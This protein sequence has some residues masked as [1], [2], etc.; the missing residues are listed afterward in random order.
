MHLIGF[1]AIKVPEALLKVLFVLRHSFLKS[2]L[3]HQAFLTLFGGLVIRGRNM[4]SDKPCFRMINLELEGRR[5]GGREVL[6]E[7][8]LVSFFIFVAS[9]GL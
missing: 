4:W 2:S 7:Q 6:Q 3:A 9:S 5:E 1:E 8:N